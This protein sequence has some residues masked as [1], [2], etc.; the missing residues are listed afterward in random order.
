MRIFL[1]KR[2]NELR[3]E[4]EVEQQNLFGINGYEAPLENLRI[5]YNLNLI[6]HLNFLYSLYSNNLLSIINY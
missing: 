3:D 2:L 4:I 6:Q 1:Q 5:N